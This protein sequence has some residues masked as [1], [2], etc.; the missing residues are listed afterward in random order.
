MQLE[1]HVPDRVCQIPAHYYAQTVAV[2][3]YQLD[4]EEL[5]RVE[6][7]T[8]QEHKSSRG[9]VLRDD[10]EYVFGGKVGC[11]GRGWSYG[12]EGGGGNVV[13]FELRLG[14][15][16]ARCEQCNVCLV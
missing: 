12:D 8:R 16:L 2:S 14:S 6:L 4:V 5:A 15:V 10:G 1:G 13:V 11:V 3:G 7:D 9:V